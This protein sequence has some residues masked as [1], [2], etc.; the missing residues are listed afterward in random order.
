MT[1]KISVLAPVNLTKK[2]A[3]LFEPRL[4]Y[5]LPSLKIKKLTGPFITNSGIVSNAK[6]LVNECYHNTMRGQYTARL[7]EVSKYYHDA[8]EDPE[9]LIVLDDDETYLLI[10][11]TWHN[12]YYHWLCETLPRLIKVRTKVD[13]MILLLPSENQL[14]AFVK[15]TLAPFNFKGIFYVPAGKGVLVRRLCMPQSPPF[16]GAHNAKSL[17]KLN[18]LYVNYVKQL[19]N[20]K[21]DV[22]KRIYVSRAKSARRKIINESAVFDVMHAFN[23]S[24]IYSEDYTFFEQVAIYSNAEYL[25]GIHGA[26]LTNMIFMPRHSKVLEFHKRIT[27]TKDH[28]SV[29]YWYLADALRHTYYHQICEPSDTDDDF[30]EADFIVD[31]ELLKCNVELMLKVD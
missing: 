18:K 14:S 21:V 24:I 13:Q 25:I 17:S 30:F 20:I 22:G 1:K 2:D 8:R 3:F 23:F 26:A 9:K 27:N 28:H 11:H 31:V 6:G 15:D 7:N 12:N 10:H 19:K 4:S 29:V 16:M 5:E